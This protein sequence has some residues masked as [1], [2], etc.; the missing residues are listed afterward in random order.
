MNNQP[1]RG[2]PSLYTPEIA[3]AICE[4]LSRGIPLAEIC[5]QDGM[6]SVRTVSDWKGLHEGFSANFTHARDEGFDVIAADTLVIIDTVPQRQIT[7]EGDKVDTGHVA[8]LK[9]RAEQRL[10]L[11]AKWDWKRYGDRQTID[12]ND[13][14]P[15]TPEQVEARL[16]E[17]LAKAKLAASE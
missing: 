8:W 3:E 11:L 14:T 13:V 6:P 16:A 2:R 10:K 17:L 15:R 7:A 4:Q 5:R 9:N 12:I 1:K